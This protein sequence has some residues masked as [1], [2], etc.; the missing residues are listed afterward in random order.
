M[1]DYYAIMSHFL[2]G[3]SKI[4]WIVL[5]EISELMLTIN[6]RNGKIL[7]SVLLRIIRNDQ[8]DKT[9]RSRIWMP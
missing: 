5:P 3:I 1:D 9:W 7:V 6:L 4:Y 8:E 2:S